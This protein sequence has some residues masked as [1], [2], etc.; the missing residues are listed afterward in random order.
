MGRGLGDLPKW[1]LLRA[2]EGL[3][4]RVQMELETVENE[5]DRVS[6]LKEY[7]TA[8]LVY[9]EIK[10][11]Y[12]HLP[13]IA[14]ARGGRGWK[15]EKSKLKAYGAISATTSMAAFGLARRGLIKV[16]TSQ[17]WLIDAGL[18]M[19]DVLVG[20]AFLSATERIRYAL[21]RRPSCPHYVL[22]EVIPG[23]IT[24]PGRPIT[25]PGLAPV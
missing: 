17:I 19:A 16:Q 12:F 24:R 14:T 1:M 25:F 11:E 4:E 8:D 23:T 3:F 15:F 18:A 5:R 20:S 13:L 21:P 10:A 9:P 7:G 6:R 22:V 2:R